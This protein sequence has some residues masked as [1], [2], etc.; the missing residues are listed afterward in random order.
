MLAQAYRVVR[1]DLTWAKVESTC[2]GAYD[3]SAYDGL[4]ETLEKHS[5]RPY[6]ILDYGNPKCYP[7]SAADVRPNCTTRDTCTGSCPT[8]PLP[9]CQDGTFYCCAACEGVHPCR[10]NLHLRNCACNGPNGKLR[11]P[12]SAGCDTRECIGAFARFARAVAL[13]YNGR[14]IVFECL[15]EPNGMGHDNATTIAALCSAAGAEFAAAGET[16]V[17]PA[18]AG[19]PHDY[20]GAAIGAGLLGG[21]GALSVHP[22]RGTAPETVL[23]DW[24]ALRALVRARGLTPEQRDATPLVSGEWGYTTA[25]APPCTYNDRADEFR[26]AAYL[27]RTWL[28][29]AVAGVGV[30][31]DYDWRDGQ[32]APVTECEGGFGAVRH[33]AS[34]AGNA[35][36][37]FDPKPKYRAA[38]ALQR[39]LGGFAAAAQRIAPGATRVQ[40]AAANVSAEGVFVLP[41][42]GGDAEAGDTPAF[43]VWANTSVPALFCSD[44]TPP[45]ERLDCGHLHINRSACLAQDNPLRPAGGGCCWNANATPGGGPQCYKSGPLATPFAFNVTFSAVGRNTPPAF[46]K[47]RIGILGAGG[48]GSV[49]GG[50]LAVAGHDVTLID[51]WFEHIGAVQRAGELLVRDADG[52]ETRCAPIA[53]LHLKDLQALNEPFDMGFVAVNEYDAGWAAACLDRYVKPTA[54][55][56]FLACFMN[57]INDDKMA[58]AVA[59]SGG[60]ARVVGAIMTI[61]AAVYDP[62]VALRTDKNSHCFKIGELAPPLETARAALLAAM[63][64]E[65]FP[66]PSS[67]TL[68]LWGQRWSKLIINCMNNA[69]AGL[70]GWKTAHTRT[71]AHTQPVAI[72]L[73]AE[74]VRVARQAGIAQDTVMGLAPDAILAAA[75]V[76]AAVEG[77]TG[78]G[79]GGQAEG[80]ANTAAGEAVAPQS[81]PVAAAAAKGAEPAPGEA[82]LR[83]APRA[84]AAFAARMLELRLRHVAKEC[85]RQL[86]S[87][88]RSD[89]LQ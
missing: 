36:Q 3:F 86:Q 34:A 64:D 80:A 16:F 41:F 61:S 44:A 38:L 21:V 33:N 57:G 73:A 85:A 52:A 39:A 14:G 70:T 43:A 28:T 60:T 78:E 50:Y 13:R 23:G 29:N 10:S 82:P 1:T 71:H 9:T 56:G 84:A 75:S 58:A 4:L 72:Q 22:Y 77:N 74:V 11:R 46:E 47:Q 67:V 7:P 27:A 88:R 59:G 54:E 63:L 32:P 40:A 81:E 69:L 30:S 79:E 66:E 31:I 76:G 26:Q 48:I 2:D 19:I 25:L 18:T 49:V 37:P 51:P 24:A 20:L 83:L 45:D 6:L 15:N 87:F 55:G 89:A 42:C 65:A 62:G 68:N 8:A 17:G 35:S 5:V 53:A 12:G